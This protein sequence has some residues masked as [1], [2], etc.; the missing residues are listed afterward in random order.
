MKLDSMNQLFLSNYIKALEENDL[1][2]FGYDEKT[3]KSIKVVPILLEYFDIYKDRKMKEKQK[4]LKMVEE[5]SRGWHIG[6]QE[7]VPLEV[8]K[9]MLEEIYGSDENAD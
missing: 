8:V 4:Y 3:D 1:I 5:K 2:S 6:E 7:L 9:G